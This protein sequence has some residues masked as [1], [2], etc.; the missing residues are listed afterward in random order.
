MW[1]DSQKVRGR[2]KIPLKYF[3]DV[4]KNVFANIQLL[5][6]NSA[7]VSM[8]WWWVDEVQKSK[9]KKKRKNC[10]HLTSGRRRRRSLTDYCSIDFF[11]LSSLW[12]ITQNSSSRF[13]YKMRLSQRVWIYKCD[14]DV[15]K[16][17]KRAQ[18]KKS[19]FN[20]FVISNVA[21]TLRRRT[22]MSRD[23]FSLLLVAKKQKK[24]IFY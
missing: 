5:F 11:S 20:S 19:I 8:I 3:G 10:F 6:L 15:Y 21:T 16:I 14:C 13:F 7:C 9:K 2:K 17:H 23:F 18:E 1:C 12:K 24:K 22:I 4:C